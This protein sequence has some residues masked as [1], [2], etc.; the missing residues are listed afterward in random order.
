M[1]DDS[2]L[3]DLGLEIAPD[4]PDR[5][6]L[7]MFSDYLKQQ[8]TKYY[9]TAIRKFLEVL[10][11][12]YDENIIELQK[13]HQNY[14]KQMCPADATGQV[15]RVIRNFA[16]VATAG[17]FAIEH[18]ILPWNKGEVEKAV[19]FVL[20]HWLKQRNG[21]NSL[22]LTQAIERLKEV[23]QQ[24]TL[25]FKTLYKEPSSRQCIFERAIREP[26]GYKI[27][28]KKGTWIYF[29]ENNPLKNIYIGI[30]KDS[31]MKELE[32]RGWLVKNNNGKSL[33]SIK[34]PDK[35]T[36]HGIAVYQEKIS[37]AD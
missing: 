27:E 32:T 19:R 10:I 31:F 26:F 7:S 33:E 29:I 3:A 35:N 30:S 5:T 37:C 9:G 34:V 14:A 13:I 22:E 24:D 18:G 17:E 11:N 6:K 12:N 8:S 36:A 4:F 1:P 28:D 21:A 23:I 2:E 25:H 20:D 15:I 16:L